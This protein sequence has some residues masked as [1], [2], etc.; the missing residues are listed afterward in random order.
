[1]GEFHDQYIMSDVILLADV[2]QNFRKMCLKYYKL[3]PCHYL[4]SP[5]L[6]WDANLKM[7]N[8]NLELM[9]DVDMLQFIEKGKRGGLSYLSH[10]YSKRNNKY[11]RECDYSSEQKY[12]M[13]ID[14]NNLYGWVISQY[15]PTGW[16]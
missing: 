15:L 5:G 8:I 3:D 9:T 10:R 2:F 12:T 14:A 16:F 7:T 6:R 1:M 4:S 13:F 11:L